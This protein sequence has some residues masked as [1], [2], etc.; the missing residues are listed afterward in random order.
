[1]SGVEGQPYADAPRAMLRGGA[2]ASTEGLTER[3]YW[4]AVHGAE[5]KEWR[6]SHPT[7]RESAT[8]PRAIGALKSRLKALLGARLVAA[9]RD[10]DD[11]LLWDV[12]LPEY[13]GGFAGA[14]AVEV[15]S[16]P[17][18]FLVGLQ[19]RF[20]LVPYGV[21]YSPVGVQLNRQVFASN[22]IDPAHVIHADFLAPELH[23][24]Y[25][26]AFD[27]VL[28]RGF[29]EHFTDA[30]GVIAKHLSLLREGGLLLVTIPNIRGANYL[31]SWLFHREVLAMHNLEIMARD[32]FAA[33]FPPE[34]VRPLLCR[35]YGTFNFHLQNARADSFMRL[36]LALCAKLQLPLN[37]LFRLMLKSQ[38]AESPW[39]SPS[40]VFVGIKR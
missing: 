4:D 12:V 14:K 35:Y 17:G 28:S 9:F 11:Y 39:F 37:V 40:L 23:E 32:N 7:R 20:G 24:R 16:A 34:T 6:R 22:G 26:E 18:D 38:G 2:V 10:Y 27:V 25:R 21:E 1:M 8:P 3:G 30:R 5:D 29:I 31:L 15:G 19:R 33:L 36:P 13:L